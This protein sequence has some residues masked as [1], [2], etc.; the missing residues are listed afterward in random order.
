M[1]SK[2]YYIYD[3][4][5][6]WCWG[7]RPVW[8]LLQQHLPKSI[9]VEYVVGGLAADSDSAMP[10]AQQ[11]MIQNHWRTIEQKLGTRFNHDFWRVNT[12]R[13]STYNA[14]RAAIAANK[15]SCPVSYTHL[16]LPT[17]CSV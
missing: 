9:A 1:S 4:M 16:T 13:R 14:C 5:C 8:D 7:Y 17:I 10:I 3:P 15:Q 2:L 11:Q 12:P 6:S